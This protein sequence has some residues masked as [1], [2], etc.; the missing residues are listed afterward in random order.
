MLDGPDGIEAQR[1]GHFSQAQF[2]APDLAVRELVVRVLKDQSVA[3]VH[4]LLLA[5]NA[6]AC[7][8][9]ARAARGHG[10][11]PVLRLRSPLTGPTSDAARRLAA[12]L[13]A[14]RATARGSLP[15]VLIA[16]GE[17]TLRLGAASRGKQDRP[18]PAAGAMTVRRGRRDR[19]GRGGRNQELALE[20]ARLLAGERGWCLLCAGTDG[21]DGPT[22]AAGAIVDGG[23]V[24]RATRVGR[25]VDAALARHD[26]YPLLAAIGAK[27]RNIEIG[28]AGGGW[29]RPCDKNA[30]RMNEG[31][32]R[33][34]RAAVAQALATPTF[35]LLVIGGGINGA[36]I[37]RD[38]AMRGLQVA[39]V[40]QGDF[41]S[42][43]SSKSSKL[44][45]GG[46]RYLEN[47]EFSLVL[48]ASRERDRLRR[49]LAPHLVHPMP[50][51]FPVFDG[52]PVGRLRLTAG[53]WVY[54][55]LAAFRTIA[56]HRSWGRRVTLRHEPR[57][58]TEGLRGAR[59]RAGGDRRRR[60]RRQLLRRRRVLARGN[61]APRRAR[62]RPLARRHV[63]GRGA[64]DRQ[65]DRAV[66][67]RRPTARGSRGDTRPAPYEG[68][69]RDRAAGASRQRA[70]D[71]RPR[72]A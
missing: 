2:V 47:F 12:R 54:D 8:A 11:A 28:T 20:V 30:A 46:L 10:F 16:G 56:R 67:R 41:A 70:R 25:S 65:R 3:N 26:V 52:D 61:G 18:G 51:V 40:E 64:T 6:T 35:D 57:L 31:A 24:A 14:L 9:A 42:G 7:A 44:I 19:G 58:R 34:R 43:T 27:T 23:T 62:R 5:G 69:A 33:A 17:T 1:L 49:H 38:A 63:H 36:G 32:L 59:D 55:G 45:H 72:A 71:R 29:R 4:K 15:A 22:D 21:I 50:F 66:A 60:R 37:A 13:R 39:L 68:R 48:E 53:L